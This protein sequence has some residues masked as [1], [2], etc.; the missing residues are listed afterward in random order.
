MINS[1]FVLTFMEMKWSVSMVDA[2]KKISLFDV[3]RSCRF[4][5][6]IFSEKK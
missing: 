6:T 2:K 1:K 4:S 5:F 3:I